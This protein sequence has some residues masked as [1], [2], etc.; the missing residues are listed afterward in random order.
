MKL[1]RLSKTVLFMYYWN[2][3]R[4]ATPQGYEVSFA[5]TGSAEGITN[6]FSLFFYVFLRIIV[7][8]CSLVFC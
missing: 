1:C 2:T 5:G 7:Y 4:D 8:L 6:F 3:H